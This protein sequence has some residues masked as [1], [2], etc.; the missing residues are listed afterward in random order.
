MT[1]FK[2]GDKVVH[3]AG[4]VGKV[5]RIT[6]VPIYTVRWERGGYKTDCKGHDLRGVNGE[7]TNP[8]DQV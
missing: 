6:H 7:R 4:V 1:Q 2:V 5:I 3:Q 8:K